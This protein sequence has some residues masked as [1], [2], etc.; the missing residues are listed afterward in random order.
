MTGP[1]AADASQ[2]FTVWSRLA[3]TSVVPPGPKA[4]DTTRLAC[5]AR[6]A[7]HSPVAK[8]HS[9]TGPYSLPEARHFPSGLKATDRTQE[10]CPLS[11]ASS[12]AVPASHSLTVWSSHPAASVRPSGL[13]A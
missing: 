10:V 13:K 7:R 3:E 5:P 8:S 12:L 6:V 1:L 9:L 11:R 4:R 2:T